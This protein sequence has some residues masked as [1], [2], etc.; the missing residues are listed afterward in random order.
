MGNLLRL[1][2]WTV[3]IV[4]TTKL[5]ITSKSDLS[6][7]ESSHAADEPLALNFKVQEHEHQ[8]HTDIIIARCC[9]GPQGP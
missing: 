7:N 6:W 9:E 8:T 5:A 2:M 1:T 3:L 4:T